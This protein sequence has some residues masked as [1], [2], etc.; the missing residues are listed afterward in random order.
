M[1]LRKTPRATRK[2]ACILSDYPGK[3]GRGGYAVGLDTAQEC[4]LDCRVLREAG[5]DIGPLPP[6]DDLMRRLE[7]RRRPNA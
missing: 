2:I 3:S 7:R 5:Y 1:N 6:A 4:R